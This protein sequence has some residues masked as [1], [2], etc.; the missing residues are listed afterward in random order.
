MLGVAFFSVG[1][2][3]KAKECLV[4]AFEF[5]R[6]YGTIEEESVFYLILSLCM[7]KEDNIREG[8]SNA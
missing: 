3:I 7:F 2:S 6:K 1:E 4:K 5:E 8:K